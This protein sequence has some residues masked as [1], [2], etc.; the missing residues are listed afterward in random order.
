MDASIPAVPVSRI[1]GLKL[2]DSESTPSLPSK[3]AIVWLTGL[4]GSGKTTLATALEKALLAENRRVCVLD[5]DEL[6]RG[7]NS[8]LG[9]SPGE[10]TENVRRV[11][12]IA[13]LMAHAGLIVIVALISPFRKDRGNAR[14]IAQGGGIEFIEVYLDCPLD[15]CEQR[16]PKGLYRKARTGKLA[17]FTGIDSGYEPPQAPE[18]ALS[19]GTQSAGESMA[20]L[21]DFLGTRISVV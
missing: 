20:V 3:G 21:F 16:D 6:R 11:A 1:H 19:T 7:V 13:R 12:E 17:A 15:V 4:S 14:L 2:R 9:F 8:D 5:G 18:I 10:R